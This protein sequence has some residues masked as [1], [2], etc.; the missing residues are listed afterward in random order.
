M[1]ALSST[2]LTRTLP[3]LACLISLA[4]CPELDNPY[5]ELPEA[6]YEDFVAEVQPVVRGRCAFLGCHGNEDLALTLYAVG[7]L[8]ATPLFEDQPLDEIALSEAELAWNYDALRMRLHDEADPARSRL[9]LKCLD[10]D[11]G[12]I[13]HAGVVVFE[14]E[15]DPDYQILLRWIGDAL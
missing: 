8:R 14:D 9:L 2:L 11:K 13:A 4:G 3:L 5:R 6:D 12:G 15:R 7:F 10:P 1:P